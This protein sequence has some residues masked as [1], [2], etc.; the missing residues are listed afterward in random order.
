MFHDNSVRL[1]TCADVKWLA[2]WHE[3]ADR[4]ALTLDGQ[5][6]PTRYNG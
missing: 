3:S 4:T 6:G 5:D 1:E 2:S